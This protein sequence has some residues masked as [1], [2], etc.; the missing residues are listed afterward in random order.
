[1][2]WAVFGNWSGAVGVVRSKT[3][4]YGPCAYLWTYL[5]RSLADPPRRDKGT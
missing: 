4:S 2:W 5:P 3:G 1:M